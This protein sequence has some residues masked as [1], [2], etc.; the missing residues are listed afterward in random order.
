[1]VQSTLKRAFGLPDNPYEGYRKGL[2]W[3]A[4]FRAASE[5]GEDE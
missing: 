5:L 3:K 2:G 4:K 1:V